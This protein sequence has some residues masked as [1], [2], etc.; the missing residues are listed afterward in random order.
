MQQ[1]A[2]GTMYPKKIILALFIFALVVLCGK[3]IFSQF[4]VFSSEFAGV[5]DEIN[6][7]AIAPEL[8]RSHALAAT[9]TTDKS[10]LLYRAEL[11]RADV[12]WFYSHLVGNEA[13]ARIILENANKNDI[14][15]PLA[16]ALAWEESRY[17]VRAVNRNATSIDRGLF[18]LNNKA[19]PNLTERD[20]F[21]PEKNAQHGLTHLGYCLDL[22]GNEV[23]ALAM[24]NA[25]TTKVRNDK[26]PKRTL[27]YVSRILS[28]RDGIEA[29]FAKQVSPRYAI[30][31]AG[32]VSVARR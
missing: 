1:N 15:P 20:F 2:T 8:F 11:S 7:A 3:I 14:P 22:S 4:S 5:G 24:C 29:L 28:H 31:E 12:L 6:Q 16:F 27:D 25:G 17:Q 9:N 32:K 13:I 19:F 23:A 21:N 10:L 30:D 26:T 18:Q